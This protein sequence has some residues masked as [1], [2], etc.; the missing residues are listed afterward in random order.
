MQGTNN[1]CT[2]CFWHWPILHV[3]DAATAAVPAFGAASACVA[4]AAA[5]AA[6]AAAPAASSDLANVICT[7]FFASGI[8]TLLQ[9]FIGDR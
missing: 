7:I 4:T 9:T 3:A 8:I 5:A 2:C 6:A 1:G